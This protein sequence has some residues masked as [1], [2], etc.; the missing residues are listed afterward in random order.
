MD[1]A[2]QDFL[3]DS[4]ELAHYAFVLRD[5]IESLFRWRYKEL[6]YPLLNDS[7]R[8][9][10]KAFL[11][12]LSKEVSS[13]GMLP[14]SEVDAAVNA[15][16]QKLARMFGDRFVNL[17]MENPERCVLEEGKRLSIELDWEFST[18]ASVI[19]EVFWGG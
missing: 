4:E 10:H 12:E 17:V 19:I 1:K 16:I 14:N 3:C 15:F 8:E 13:I 5:A 18:L 6:S 2:L 11:D 7:E 9:Q